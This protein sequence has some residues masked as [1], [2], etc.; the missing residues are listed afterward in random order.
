M[1]TRALVSM[2][3][4]AW[5]AGGEGQRDQLCGQTAPASQPSLHPPVPQATL[6]ATTPNL[7]LW[8]RTTC[9]SER[10]KKAAAAMSTG[11]S[12]RH[13]HCPTLSQGMVELDQP[14]V[15]MHLHPPLYPFQTT[16]PA[17]DCP[18]PFC[19]TRAIFVTTT[20]NTLSIPIFAPCSD[21]AVLLSPQPPL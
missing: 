16:G 3:G 2:A 13:C 6:G 14:V 9:P 19:K 20:L 21:G 15:R 11:P 10:A 7:A 17:R 18:S 5:H 4:K 8:G 1:A 12:V